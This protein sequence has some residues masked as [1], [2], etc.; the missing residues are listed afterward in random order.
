MPWKVNDLMASRTEFVMLAQQ[1]GAN[2]RQL[3][4]NFGISRKTG[5]KWLRRFEGDGQAGLADQSRRPKH[6]PDLTS[7]D[8]EAKILRVRQEHPAWGG[9]KIRAFLLNQ[10][11]REIPVPSTITEIL[12]RQGLLDAQECE[13]H[14]AFQRFEHA[15]PN[16]LWQMDF[17]GHVPLEVG[18][19]CH[20]LTVLDDHSRFAIVLKACGNERSE[21]VQG[22]LTTS[23]RN[24]GLPRRMLMDNGPPWGDTRENGY[25]KLTVWLLRLCIDVTH[26]RPFHPQTQGK[27]E[28]FHRT[29]KAEVLAGRSLR[30]LPESDRRFAEWRDVYNMQRPHEAL[31]LEV[32]VRR[33]QVSPRV[34]P[35]KLPAIEYGPGD[36]V[37]KVQ[38]DGCFTYDG[39]EC[40][41]STAFHGYPI[42]LRP[43]ADRDGVMDVWF[44]QHYVGDLDLRERIEG[45]RTVHR[46]N[47]EGPPPG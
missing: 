40:W 24:Y 30:D 42:A 44:C 47:A 46:R 23:F 45:R 17:K 38:D 35:E 19:R 27:D 21:T 37:R 33:Y 15:A 12:R 11:H 4:S 36:E 5:Y 18:G 16:D 32:P 6:S 3:C 1:E 34:F 26:G 10:G 43:R 41:I 2:I 9:R 25:T 13:K 31:G 7:A 29:L 8:V 22:E 28:R 20:P 14:R 39:Q